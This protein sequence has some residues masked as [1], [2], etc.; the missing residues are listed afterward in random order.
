MQITLPN[1]PESLGDNTE[2]LQREDA[3]LEFVYE[4]FL[5]DSDRGD[6]GSAVSCPS[7]DMKL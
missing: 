5:Q 3:H 7:L 6:L 4:F 1:S 2:S